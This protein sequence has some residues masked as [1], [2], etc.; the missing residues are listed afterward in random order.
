MLHAHVDIPGI[1]AILSFLA[2]LALATYA[3][4]AFKKR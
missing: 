1:S 3:G 4:K 2:I